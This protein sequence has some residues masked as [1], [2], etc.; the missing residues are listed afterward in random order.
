[1]LTENSIKHYKVEFSKRA[2]KDFKKFDK[3]IFLLLT[4]WIEKNLVNCENPRQHGKGLTAN[5]SGMWRYRVGN[6]RIIANINE[7]TVTILSVTAGH[8]REIYDFNLL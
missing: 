4:N 2:L 7:D 1:M 8:R 5:F 3:Q 6:Y